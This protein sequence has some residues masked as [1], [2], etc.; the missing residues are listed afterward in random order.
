MDKSIFK[1]LSSLGIIE[2]VRNLEKMRKMAMIINPYER[3]Q[4]RRYTQNSKNIQFSHENFSAK[5]SL[6]EK[7]LT[8]FVNKFR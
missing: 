3:Q 5:S 7:S 4:L 8:D 2:R 6:N 1:A